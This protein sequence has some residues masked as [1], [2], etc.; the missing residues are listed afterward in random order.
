MRE[1]ILLLFK[2]FNLFLAGI[3]AI[4]K[5]GQK[6]SYIVYNLSTGRAEQESQFPSDTESFLG[7]EPHNISLIS[8]GEVK[9]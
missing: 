1:L 9:F 8:A 5:T 7:L 3:H 2:L 6:L 4:V